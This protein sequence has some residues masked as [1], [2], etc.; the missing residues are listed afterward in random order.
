[1]NADSL[2]L[3]DPAD[4]LSDP[5]SSLLSSSVSASASAT[6][7]ASLVPPASRTATA[8]VAIMTYNILAGG[9]PRLDCIEQVIHAAGA[10]LI[11]VQ[12]VTRPACLARLAERLGMHDAVGWSPS[13]WHVGMLSR[14]PILS[15]R[16]HSGPM[17]T[18]ALLEAVVELPGGERLSV[19]TTHLPAMFSDRR[20]GEERRLRELD[21]ILGHL[22][23]A[24]LAGL[25]EG[26][27]E[28]PQVL[29]GDFNSV[30][31]GERFRPMAVLRHAVAVDALRRA[32]GEVL[33]GHPG[34]DYILP[35]AVRPLRTLLAGASRQPALSWCA[36][37][38]A[39]LSMPRAV[40]RRMRAAGYVD[41]YAALRPDPRTRE[42][43]CPADAPGGRIDYIWATPD[44]AKRLVACEVLTDA[45]DCP[46][47]RA[48]DHRPV[49][50]TF[51]TS[52]Q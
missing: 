27:P 37:R 34:V 44:F 8:T 31:P 1:M 45:P 22:R 47:T 25:E 23:A 49:L 38:L 21:V 3:L 46:V 24:G 12:E 13:G 33:E 7:S 2:D 20:R 41:C 6:A 40:I 36:D 11:G 32:R 35:P 51:Q 16:S 30:A 52:G 5:S 28:H 43:T 50:A 18:R 17:L 10:D 14:W 9:G 4:S 15:S 48:S 19:F 42:L 39:G 26:A 29:L